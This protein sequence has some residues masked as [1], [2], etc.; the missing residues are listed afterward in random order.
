MIFSFSR[1]LLRGMERGELN[2]LVE[3]IDTGLAFH[4]RAPAGLYMDAGMRRDCDPTP[5]FAIAILRHDLRL[6]SYATI[7]DCDPAICDCDP[8]I[9]IAILR[10][11]L[12]SYDFHCDPAM[13]RGCESFMCRNPLRSFSG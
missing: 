9:F 1:T 8:A 3:R 12:R 7:C 10:F 5:R 13:L 2:S 6:R 4:H 11:S